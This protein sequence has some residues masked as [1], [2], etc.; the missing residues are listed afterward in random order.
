MNKPNVFH[1]GGTFMYVHVVQTT[2]NSRSYLQRAI[3]KGCDIVHRLHSLTTTP[4]SQIVPAGTK[5]PK[6]IQSANIN[7]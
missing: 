3:P 7:G 2:F 1:I 5:M 6:T 4:S